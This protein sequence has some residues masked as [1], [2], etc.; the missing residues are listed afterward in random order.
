[1]VKCTEIYYRNPIAI[2]FYPSLTFWWWTSVKACL[3]LFSCLT[4]SLPV[5]PIPHITKVFLNKF[6]VGREGAAVYKTLCAISVLFRTGQKYLTPR[7]NIIVIVHN[8]IDN[9]K[10]L[11]N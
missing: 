4:L 6:S 9:D 3:L 11:N 10:T 7:W 2:Y 8:L 1:M 5:F